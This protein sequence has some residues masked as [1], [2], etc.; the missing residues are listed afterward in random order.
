MKKQ[1]I[2]IPTQEIQQSLSP[3]HVQQELFMGNERFISNRQMKRDLIKDAMHT[4]LHGQFPIAVVLSCIDSRSIPEIVFDQG[5]GAIITI[6]VAGNIINDDI[7]ASM[8]Y[9]TKYVGAKLI[10]VMGHSQC[11]LVSAAYKNKDAGHLRYLI[12]KIKPAVTN[13]KNSTEQFDCDKQIVDEIAKQNVQNMVSKITNKSSVIKQLVDDKS[14]H[15]VGAF[16]NLSTGEVR[17]FCNV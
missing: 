2:N 6:R 14:I 5:I 12:E 7:L 8:E 10:V 3:A 15:I 1:I 9:A 11:G 16:H 17:F 4:A 13:I